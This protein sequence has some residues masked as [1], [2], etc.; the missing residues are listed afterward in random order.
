MFLGSYEFPRPGRGASPYPWIECEPGD[1]FRVVTQDIGAAR[2][3]LRACRWGF[4]RM[5]D[6]AP[7]FDVRLDGVGLR[8]ERVG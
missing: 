8:V 3:S 2:N 7:E 1:W 5:V 4:V 6:W